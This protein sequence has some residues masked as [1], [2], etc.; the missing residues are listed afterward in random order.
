[1]ITK[2]NIHWLRRVED[3]WQIDCYAPRSADVYALAQAVQ[4]ALHGYRGGVFE[5]IALDNVT[6]DL[7]QEPG[8]RRISM[9]F[10]VHHQE[11][12]P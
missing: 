8:L 1:M 9:D 3:R 7:H 4:V 2:P 6:D 12:Y 10:I 5:R 11:T